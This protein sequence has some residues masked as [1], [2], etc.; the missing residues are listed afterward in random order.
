MQK[1]NTTGRYLGLTCIAAAVV[2]I[3]YLLSILN[4]D[5]F[6]VSVMSSIYFVSIDVM[7]VCLLNFTVY[8]TKN[9]LTNGLRMA[10]RLAGL[11]ACFEAVLFA[12]NPFYEIALGL[13]PPGYGDRPVRLPDEAPVLAASAV[14]L[15]AGCGSPGPAD[16]EA[17]PGSLGEYRAQFLYVIGGI[18][19][20]VAV[21]GVF[22]YL[23]GVS[24][25]NLLDYSIC[26]YSLTAFLM[27]WCCFHYSTHGMLNR[28]K[29]SMEK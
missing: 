23:P 12:L 13:C 17:V 8:F 28:L 16:R 2:D 27:Y 9:N 22:L 11:Y 10:L 4:D 7:L 5:Y 14:Y 25:F 19:A 3:S 6:R 15:R 29:T 26:G 1:N 20:L 21:N 24:V 18:V